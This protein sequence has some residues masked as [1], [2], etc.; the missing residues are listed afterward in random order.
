MPTPQK[1]HPSLAAQSLGFPKPLTQEVLDD[2]LTGLG[3]L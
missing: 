1:A 3:T 2:P